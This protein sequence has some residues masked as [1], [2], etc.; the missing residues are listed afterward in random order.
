MATEFKYIGKEDYLEFAI[1]F[2]GKVDEVINDPIIRDFFNGKELVGD[3][4]RERKDTLRLAESF[5]HLM[6][7]HEEYEACQD[8]VDHYPELR[9]DC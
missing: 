5:L 9:I 4:K 1:N 7:D 3:D 6:C 8:I 2:N